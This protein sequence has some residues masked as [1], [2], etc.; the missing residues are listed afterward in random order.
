MKIAIVDYGM[1]NLHSV[2]KAFEREAAGHAEI[3]LTADPAVVAPPTRWCFPGQGAMPDCMRE[4]EARG[5][6]PP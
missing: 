1:G 6:R 2:A 5:L 4:L 3:I